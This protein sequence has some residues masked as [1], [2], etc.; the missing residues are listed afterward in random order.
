MRISHLRVLHVKLG[1]YLP[2]SET[3]VH[4]RVLNPYCQRPV[5]VLAHTV[6]PEYES[7]ANLNFYRLDRSSHL[8]QRIENALAYRFFTYPYYYQVLRS[9][10][11]DLIH[12]H[13]SGAGEA[14][15]W[16]AQ[17]LHI[18]LIVNFYGIETKQHIHDPQWLP[19]YRRLYRLVTAFI[20]SSDYMKAGM[21]ASGCPPRKITVIRCG[22]DTELFS[23]EPLAWQPDQTL[24]LLS[25]ARLH[26]EKGLD[27]LLHACAM[28]NEAGFRNWQLEIAGVG[29]SEVA[30]RQQAR[31]LGLDT[32]VKFLG[33]LPQNQIV[34]LLRVAHIMVLPSRQESQ[35]VALQEA[36]ATCTPVIASRVEGI[37]EGVVDGETGLLVEPENPVALFNAILSLIKH[38]D[39]LIQMGRAGRQFVC[40]TFSRQV[41]YQE[42]CQA[43]E[44]L[45]KK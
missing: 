22:I 28:L 38:P 35:G 11:P 13:A 27:I 18:P 41:E 9:D 36:Q 37:P 29:T 15:I 40:S 33:A 1:T 26:P 5:S 25:I 4:A 16:P 23:G 2:P 24:R 31:E 32:Q 10:R 30:L 14:M 6:T 34:G 45:L 17:H 39:M 3:F 8:R 21:I 19:R 20:C 43:Y 44:A 42:L 12:A 7:L